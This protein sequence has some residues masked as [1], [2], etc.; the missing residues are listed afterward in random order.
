MPSNFFQSK[1]GTIIPFNNIDYMSKTDS[2]SSGTIVK[3][4]LK[5]GMIIEL[6]PDD[7][8]TFE[9]TYAA[10]LDAAEVEECPDS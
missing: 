10:W 5:S 4:I 3:V 2:W 1:F 6:H 7:H 8:G 9:H